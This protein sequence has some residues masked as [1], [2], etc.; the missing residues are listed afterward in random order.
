MRPFFNLFHQEQL[1][2]YHQTPQ[3]VFILVLAQWYSNFYM[4]PELVNNYSWWQVGS[5]PVSLTEY[6]KSRVCPALVYIQ[7]RHMVCGK[8]HIYHDLILD[9]TVND[10]AYST[11]LIHEALDV[12]HKMLMLVIGWYHNTFSHFVVQI[13]SL[14]YQ[15]GWVSIIIYGLIQ[16]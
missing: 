9:Q 5:V 2:V 4:I 8:F 1:Y 7:H 3:K 11:P 13:Q 16:N 15:G 10:N 14:M 6:H 12:N